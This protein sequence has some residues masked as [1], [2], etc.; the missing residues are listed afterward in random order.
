MKILRQYLILFFSVLMCTFVSKANPVIDS[1]KKNTNQP[2][3][4]SMFE[5][6]CWIQTQVS[7]PFNYE[8]ARLTGIFISS[9]G[10]IDTIDG[11]YFQN[12]QITD[13]NELAAIGEPYW[14]IRFAPDE[15]G[16]W[17]FKIVFTDTTGMVE[18]SEDSFQCIASDNPG[19]FSFDE[20]YLKNAMG[21]VFIP[22]GENLAWD[23]S[24]G[25]F[26]NYEYWI[27]SLK[28]YQVNI[29]KIFMPPWGF[30]IEWNNTG[31][32]N[33]T[34]RL[35]RA[36]ALDW[37]IEQLIENNIY[38]ILVPL[39][40]DELQDKQGLHKWP[41][42]P[43]NLENGG[44]CL[45]P[46]DFFS[47]SLAISYFKRKMRYVNSRYAF[48]PHTIM[49]E[50]F[51]EADNF[52]YYGQHRQEIQSWITEIASYL[53]HSL[54][55]RFNITAGFA[56][57]DH[58]SATWVSPQIDY[59]Q[60]HLY[61]PRNDDLSLMINT[62][63]RDYLQKYNKPVSVGE[64]ALFHINDTVIKYDPEGV[65][66]HNALWSSLFSGAFMLALPWHW[67]KYINDLGLYYH[68]KPLV[69]Y[70]SNTEIDYPNSIPVEVR[71]TSDTN[72]DLVI[73]PRFFSLE[74]KPPYD[75]FNVRRTGYLKPAESYLSEVL[76][77]NGPIGQALR[78]PPTFVADYPV[79]A[80]FVVLTGEIVSNGNLQIQLNGELVFNSEVEPQSQY[81]IEVPEGVNYIF[82]ENTNSSLGSVIEIDK[83]L[84][85]NY[86][87]LLRAF[88]LE[89]DDF[90]A[91]WYQNRQYNWRNLYYQN[92]PVSRINGELVFDH[93]TEGNYSV[94]WW[95][96]NTGVPDSATSVIVS[97]GE[98]LILRINELKWD[99]AFSIEKMVG[100]QPVYD[101][102]VM[103]NILVTPN[104][105]SYNTT[106]ITHAE[107]G[108]KLKVQ[109]CDMSGNVVREI[110]TKRYR[111][112]ETVTLEWDGCNNSGKAVAAGFYI[113]RILKENY[114]D[115]AKMIKLK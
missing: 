92:R 2:E 83:F 100:I 69:T 82:V 108:V 58:D 26:A 44:P 38:V 89:G 21:E 42:N 31:L 54:K 24:E 30:G 94:Q 9:S 104:P 103:Q 113:V 88:A 78:K 28:K 80:D 49:W 25:A 107:K 112:D 93:F 36:W 52:E 99:G 47:D 33:Y 7:N 56:I 64:F 91:G 43:Y 27:D 35:D 77:G 66:M 70:I 102:E 55:G 98:P 72:A 22:V 85:T 29:V 84:F 111:S 11:F 41:D 32:G 106:I 51:S 95:N 13:T 16:Y 8:K 67:N 76:Y 48:S 96:C 63:S 81:S 23:V 37:V 57:S 6:S 12:Y 61:E 50:V 18:T 15:L 45:Y 79:A 114:C 3:K 71:S 65:A 59:T 46:R 115:E 105:F 75:T 110:D 34:E 109:I 4:Y 101:D 17:E 19:Y 68:F 62:Q 86:A 14:K 10:I 40:H 39:I 90:A 53:K 5:L 74:N 97:S 1:V 87:P 20:R 73:E 60:L